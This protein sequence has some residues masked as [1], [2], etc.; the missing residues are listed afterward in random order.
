MMFPKINHAIHFGDAN[1]QSSR[2]HFPESDIHAQ[3]ESELLATPYPHG[4]P[5]QPFDLLQC[6]RMVSR[7]ATIVTMGRTIRGARRGWRWGI[8]GKGW[9]YS[10][11]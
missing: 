9:G 7:W 3:A 2:F 1:G 10:Q 6:I 5:L 8:E 4:D 11:M